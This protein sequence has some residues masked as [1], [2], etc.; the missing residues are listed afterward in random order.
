MGEE[1]LLP[2]A[3]TREY[4]ATLAPTNGQC[5]EFLHTDIAVLNCA[6]DL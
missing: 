5:G 6:I 1:V 2:L 3:L 4:A